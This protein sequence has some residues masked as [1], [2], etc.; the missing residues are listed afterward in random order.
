LPSPTAAIPPGGLLPCLRVGRNRR[1]WL[2]TSHPTRTERTGQI[3]GRASGA[4]QAATS[5]DLS[6]GSVFAKTY[7]RGV[8]VRLLYCSSG[9]VNCVS[10]LMRHEACGEAERVTHLLH[11]LDGRL[12]VF[13]EGPLV[14]AEHDRLRLM[15]NPAPAEVIGRI[16]GCGP[17][18]KLKF[19]LRGVYV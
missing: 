6:V 3:A 19:W 17:G 18:S 5:N 12:G 10:K 11:P 7:A 15:N 14:H 4:D 16:L 13:V 2:H 8:A 9:F 1:S